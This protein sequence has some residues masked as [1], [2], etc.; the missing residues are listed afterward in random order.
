MTVP[1]FT[2]TK[3]CIRSSWNSLPHLMAKHGKISEK[4]TG[5]L[6][7]GVLICRQILSIKCGSFVFWNG[8]GYNFW[9]IPTVGKVNSRKPAIFYHP[10]R[11]GTLK[12]L[13]K[14]CW[15]F[16]CRKPLIPN[17][18]SL[19]SLA[20]LGCFSSLVKIFTKGICEDAPNM[21]RSLMTSSYEDV[22]GVPKPINVRK[23]GGLESWERG[24]TQGRL[25]K[26][27]TM[28]GFRDTYCTLPETNS[29]F[30]PENRPPS[31]I[32]QDRIPS[33]HF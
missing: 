7:C 28:L 16:H 5:I 3:T 2:T 10:K 31:P 4:I 27:P 32:G 33:I 23:P 12:D 26:N 17:P 22:L 25:I 24:T 8:T 20:I 1:G 14:T 29:E 19:A 6:F 13:P 21:R 9:E 18:A 15:L 11:C 30:A